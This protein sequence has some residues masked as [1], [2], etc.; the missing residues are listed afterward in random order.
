MSL[1][2]NQHNHILGENKGYNIYILLKHTSGENKILKVLC[3]TLE[4]SNFIPFS[5]VSIQYTLI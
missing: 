4:I 2:D 3:Y 5:Y 1:P